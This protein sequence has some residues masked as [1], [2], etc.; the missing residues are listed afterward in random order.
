MKR[1][2]GG[3]NRRA[4]RAMGDACAKSCGAQG[5]RE[6]RLAHVRRW[7]GT[8]SVGTSVAQVEWSCG[9][10]A[11]LPI[12]AQGVLTVAGVLAV[13]ALCMCWVL[14]RTSAALAQDG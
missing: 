7:G 11:S 14:F 2:P 4:W 5:Q 1:I 12:R 6:P 8:G 3:R 9:F 10:M 13:V